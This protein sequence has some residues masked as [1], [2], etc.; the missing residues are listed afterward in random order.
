[1]IRAGLVISRHYRL[2]LDLVLIF[3]FAAVTLLYLIMMDGFDR[4][5]DWS[6]QHEDWELDELVL[7]AAIL[8]FALAVFAIR[9]IISDESWRF[10]SPP[11]SRPLCLLCR[12]H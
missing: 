12:I 6:R 9:Q 8:S 7:T 10:A 11:K 5:Y 1:M 2:L 3:G 4:F